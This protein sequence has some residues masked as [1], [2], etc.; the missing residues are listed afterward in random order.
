MNKKSG[1][2]VFDAITTTNDHMER[3]TWAPGIPLRERW[4]REEERAAVDK[5]AISWGFK[6]G[7]QGEEQGVEW[8]GLREW[9]GLRGMILDK[10]EL[11]EGME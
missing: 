11:M 8:E 6:G 10:T 9:C 1:D 4:L 5:V 3:V 7:R 2:S